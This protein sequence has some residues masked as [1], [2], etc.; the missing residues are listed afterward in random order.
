MLF[1]WLF[2]L[3]I[4]FITVVQ[5]LVK[6]GMFM[7]GLYYAT[8]ARNLSVGIGSFWKPFFTS[9]L[10]SEF[11]EHPPLV[12]GIQSILF[13]VLGE[14]IYVEKIYSFLTAITTGWLIYTIWKNIFDRMDEYRSKYSWLP[15]L[16]WI[17]IPLVSWSY[18]NNLLENT[19][20][21]FTLSSV[22]IL[23]KGIKGQINI[24]LSG[25]FSAAM[26]F[27]GTLSKGFPALFPLSVLF[28]YWLVFKTPDFKKV[29]LIT[30]FQIIFIASVFL[31]LF[32]MAGPKHFFNSYLEGQVL[33]ALKGE[34]VQGSHFFILWKLFMEIL[35]LLILLGIIFLLYKFKKLR[36]IA[37]EKNKQQ[38]VFFFLIAASA[39]LPIMVSPKQLGFYLV[40]SFPLFALG[41]ACLFAHSLKLLIDK[42]SDNIYGVKVFKIFILSVLSGVIVFVFFQAGKIGRDKAIISD[43]KKFA[44]YLI[45]NTT[46][47]M[48]KDLYPEW[49]LYAYYY[50]YYYVSLD[51]SE[52]S[53]QLLLARKNSDCIKDLQFIPLK[54]NEGSL[55]FDLYTFSLSK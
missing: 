37:S 3:V 19:M 12:F 11:Y 38:S 13:R 22:L 42:C 48:C 5:N 49:S 4:F 41:F 53:H 43:M 29:I 36:F 17:I 54:Q 21:I 20:G 7:D 8:L 44:P 23:V 16:I 46:I 47:G 26:I 32:Q 40:P 24:Y 1:G 14:S 51:C 28:F 35:P 2:V 33:R 15:I 31:I 45:S 18:S 25:L 9:T 52:Q 10:Y 34:L 55:E 50:R 30:L 39:A 27:F 6:E